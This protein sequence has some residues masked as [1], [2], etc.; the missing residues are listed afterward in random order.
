MDR[1][2]PTIAIALL[3]GVGVDVAH[4]HPL[5]GAHQRIGADQGSHLH[6]ADPGLIDDGLQIGRTASLGDFGQLA[7]VE[8]TTHLVG[9]QRQVVANDR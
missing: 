8:V 6:G 1:N 5:G 9:T 4:H 2:D 3:R 7:Q